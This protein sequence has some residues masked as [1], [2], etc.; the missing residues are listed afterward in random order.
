MATSTIREA[1]KSYSS[2][3]LG[4]YRADANTVGGDP[5]TG[6]LRWDNATQI[7]SA[8]ITIDH[9]TEDGVDIDLF[10]SLILQGDRFAI[11]DKDNSDNFQIWEVSSAPV[12]SG[13]TYWTIP[14]TLISS[15]G[16]GTSGFANN[17]RV[18]TAVAHGTIAPSP[19]GSNLDLV[20]YT[21]YGGF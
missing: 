11:Q 4:Y 19:S 16:T 17:T 3:L 2:G 6:Y 14:V 5:A 12:H 15:G 21:Q 8:N 10:L 20:S 13:A 7:N 18:F 1:G 9:V